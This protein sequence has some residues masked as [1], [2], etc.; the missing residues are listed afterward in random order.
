[1]GRSARGI[2]SLTKTLNINDKAIKTIIGEL[3]LVL[4]G[5]MYRNSDNKVNMIAS[6][7][8]QHIKKAFKDRD[9]KNLLD[10]IVENNNPYAMKHKKRIEELYDKGLG[11]VKIHKALLTSCQTE[12]EK[13]EVISPSAIRTYLHDKWEIPKDTTRRIPIAAAN[14]RRNRNN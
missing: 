7:L 4:N 5:N 10:A 3:I 6:T 11:Y 13:K 1:M 9:A 8:N 2:T 12:E 14:A